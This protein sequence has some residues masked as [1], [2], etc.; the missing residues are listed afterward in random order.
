MFS[1]VA[2]FKFVPEPIMMKNA[3]GGELYCLFFASHRQPA[4]N[5][6]SNIFK[7]RFG[8]MSG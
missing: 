1:D 2:G 7:R 6:V 4:Q 5:I 3:K 8:R